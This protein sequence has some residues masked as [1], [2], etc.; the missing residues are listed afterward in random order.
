MKKFQTILFCVLFAQTLLSAEILSPTEI[1][2]AEK[3]IT[4]TAEEAGIPQAL[5]FSAMS[6]DAA[7]SSAVQ[8]YQESRWDEARLGWE[9]CLHLGVRDFRVHYNLG[10]A[11]FRLGD[12]GRSILHYHKALLIEPNDQDAR[13]NLEHAETLRIDKEEKREI[14]PLFAALWS[15]HSAI[16]PALGA[17]LLLAAALLIGLLGCALLFVR[18][19]K[20]TLTVVTLLLVMAATFPVALS[21]G[22]KAWSIEWEP[23]AV[24][25]EQVIDIRSGPTIKDQVVATLHAGTIVEPLRREGEWVNIKVTEGLE[26]YLR[27]T[28]LAPINRKW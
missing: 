6:C 2:S 3:Q 13:A 14:D 8:L 20:Q 15:L 9:R 27:A 21:V 12:L 17:R 19:R 7:F 10:N 18:G 28:E 4:L 24:I 16:S 5:N 25:L 1:E 26:G 23:R 22:Y 11:W